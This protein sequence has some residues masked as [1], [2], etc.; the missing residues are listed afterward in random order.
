MTLKEAARKLYQHNV[1]GLVQCMQGDLL[2]EL[3]RTGWDTCL[4]TEYD[5]DPVTDMCKEI[6]QHSMTISVIAGL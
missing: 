2:I 6:Y 3:V 4:Y 1:G 5:Y